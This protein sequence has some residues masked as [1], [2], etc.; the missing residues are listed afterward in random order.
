[1]GTAGI[2]ERF[3]VITQGFIYTFVI[4]YIPA[5]HTGGRKRMIYLAAEA[6]VKPNS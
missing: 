4:L 1:M 2:N 3:E 5:I 6:V